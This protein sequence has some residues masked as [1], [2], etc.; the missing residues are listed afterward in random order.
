M[1]ASGGRA[2]SERPPRPVGE[3]ESLAGRVRHLARLRV[4]R[5]MPRDDFDD[6]DAP[7]TRPSGGAPLALIAVLVAGLVVIAAVCGGAA[8]VWTRTAR[9]AD[10]R[11]QLVT[12]AEVEA[13]RSTAVA[14]SKAN[15]RV[16]T[17]DE[18]RAL[19]LGKTMDEVSALLG[20]PDDIEVEGELLKWSY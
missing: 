13:A 16:Y 10:A 19:V 20:P 18:F 9:M 15:P 8:L 12:E 11:G 1:G 14:K 4:P 17:R 3:R 7:P 6:F 5:A 2:P